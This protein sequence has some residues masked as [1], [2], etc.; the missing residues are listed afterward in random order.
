MKRSEINTYI[1]EAKQ[2]FVSMKF[3]LPPW[4]MWTPDD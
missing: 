2:F 4:A 3:H 1:A